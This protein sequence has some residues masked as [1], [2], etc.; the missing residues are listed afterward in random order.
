MTGLPQ[1]E[2][3]VVTFLKVLYS[4]VRLGEFTAHEWNSNRKF[5][6]ILSQVRLDW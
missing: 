2:A 1:N 5:C 6:G 4:N 3:K